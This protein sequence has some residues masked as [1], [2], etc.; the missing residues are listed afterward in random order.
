M[1]KRSAKSQEH[2]RTIAYVKFDGK[3]SELWAIGK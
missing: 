2:L 3:Q 1:L